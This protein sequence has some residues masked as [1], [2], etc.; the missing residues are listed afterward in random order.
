MSAREGK[1]SVRTNE[2]LPETYVAKWFV[3]FL[4]AV[5]IDDTSR[6]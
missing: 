4:V 5:T 6:V 3:R 2:R 1:V